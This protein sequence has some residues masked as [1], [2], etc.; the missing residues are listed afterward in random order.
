MFPLGP[1]FPPKDENVFED[2]NGLETPA[3]PSVPQEESPWR[4]T[5]PIA[6]V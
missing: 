3:T 4:V 6:T 5:V 2:M 1:Q